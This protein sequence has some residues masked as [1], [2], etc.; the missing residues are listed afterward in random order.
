MSRHPRYAVY[1]TPVPGSRWWRFGCEWLGRDPISGKRL[2]PMPLN[3]I[4]PEKIESMT[5]VPRR[6]GF[7]ATLKAPF[8]LAD[9]AQVHDLHRALTDLA[10]QC[11]PID[12][13]EPTLHDMY[14]FLALLPATTSAIQA[15]AGTCVERLDFL[16]APT[17]QADIDRRR[18]APLT[19]RQEALLL[20]WGYP[21]VMEEFRF[22]L[23][24]TDRLA[25]APRRTVVEGLRPVIRTLA[26]EPL[27]L[28]ALCLFEQPAHDTPFVLT[29][30]YGFDGSIAH[31][32]R[33]AGSA[34]GRLFYVVG[35][36]GAG[37]DALLE[38]VKTRLADD[39]PVA[40]AHRYITRSSD[41]G[42]ENHVALDELEFAR[43]EHTGAFAMSWQSHGYRY[44]IGVEID[45]W[46]ARGLDVVVNGS[47]A[48]LPQAHARYPR[49]I[50]I[51]IKAPVDVLEARLRRRGRENDDDV[52]LRLAR[53]E[54]FEMPQNIN[55]IEIMNDAAL[56][57]AG[58]QLLGLLTAP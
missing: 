9:G 54:K 58:E 21:Y 27:R 7:H 53:A 14:G 57:R 25:D 48:Y 19:P 47:R 56:P 23:T 32:Q 5:A 38:Y 35:P 52:R 18:T 3:G 2:A 39:R 55:V 12:L 24:L 1:Y 26:A 46:L 51:W 16:R 15:L 34:P 50:V 13:D 37:K 42:G 28:D 8:A 33:A 4:S 20:R 29:H 43:R 6:Y 30:R 41:S 17:T 45:H 11:R 10:S 22:H 44:G 31:Y 36:S 49:M 40:F